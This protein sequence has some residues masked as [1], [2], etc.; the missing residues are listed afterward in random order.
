MASAL[1]ACSSGG[2][3]KKPA[4]SAAAST[5]VAPAA[6]TTV[7]APTSTIAPALQAAADLI[8][9]ETAI[10]DPSTPDAD[11]DRWGQ[12]QQAAVRELVFHPELEAETLGLLPD[13]VRTA[14]EAHLAAAKDLTAL[15]GPVEPD[16]PLP[17]WTI[18]TP[19]PAAVLLHHYQQAEATVG[20]PWE[21]LAAIHLVETRMG[22]IRGDSSAGARGPMQFIP[23]TWDLYG[24]GGDIESTA[25]S[26]AA[27]AR[28]LRANGALTD[29]PGALFAYNNSSRYVRA[30]TVYAQQMEADERAYLGYHGWQVYYGQRLL[31]EGTV[32][33]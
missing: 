25:D 1:V 33:P 3:E 22:R 30:V 4:A 19:E 23:S 29:M 20:V 12:V 27:A 14:T 17:H 28:L 16:R 15:N 24:Q 21:Y 26:I 11:M 9:A 5:T 8:A 13:R 6:T 31:P 32:L 10:H 7:P 2:G 18:V